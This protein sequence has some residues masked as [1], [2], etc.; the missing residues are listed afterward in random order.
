MLA[1]ETEDTSQCTP[2]CSGS[3]GPRVMLLRGKGP[4]RGGAW[5]SSNAG[6]LFHHVISKSLH[7][8]SV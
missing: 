4:V 3:L 8:I 2:H 6:F 7:V 1:H 5:L